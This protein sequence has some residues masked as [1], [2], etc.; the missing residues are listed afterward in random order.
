[1]RQQVCHKS[2]QATLLLDL[3]AC[4]C[5]YRWAG[6]ADHRSSR[7][8]QTK[9]F[10]ARHDPA[11]QLSKCPPTASPSP[12][13]TSTYSH[14]VPAMFTHAPA[15]PASGP[16]SG[17]GSTGP[18]VPCPSPDSPS[19]HSPRPVPQSAHPTAQQTPWWFLQHAR[20]R[21]HRGGR[22]GPEHHGLCPAR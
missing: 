16:A 5:P 8:L 15:P 18:H 11:E 10:R 9:A 12:N 21:S 17:S 22:S 3:T 19:P 14:A 13:A 2:D 4:L 7:E 6:Q 20:G 1:M